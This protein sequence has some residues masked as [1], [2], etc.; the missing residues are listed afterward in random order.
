MPHPSLETIAERL[1]EQLRG[2]QED[3]C[4]PIVQQVTCGK[5]VTLATLQT[6][7][8]VSQNELEQLLA[9]LPPDVEFERA[10]NIV[11]LGV[12]LVPTSHR[13]QIGGKLLYTWCAFDTVLFPPSLH[14][15]AQVQ[16]TCPV[17]GQPITF[18]ATPEGTV[19]DLFPAGSVMSLIVPAEHSDCTRATFCQQSLLFQSEQA[20]ATFLV[21]HPDVLLLS[22]EEAAYV[23][24]LV[25][26]TSSVDAT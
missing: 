3:L 14:V 1:S 2:A 16:S 13:F 19:Q 10:G 7:L 6:S 22:V 26:Q 11:G 23:G 5:P 20:A 25:A 12:T 17:T 8:Q 24:R 9:E 4:R 18:V 15:E 21:D